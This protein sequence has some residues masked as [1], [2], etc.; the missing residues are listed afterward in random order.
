MP[1]RWSWIAL[2]AGAYLAFL[3]ATFPASAAYR[4]FAPPELRMSGVAGTVWSGSASLA[5]MNG[6]PLRDL[7]WNLS[8][9][10]LLLGRAHAVFETRL[11][12]GFVRGESVATVSYIALRN[13]QVSTRLQ[14]LA[15]LLPV[16]DTRGAVSLDVTSLVIEDGWPVELVGLARAAQIEVAPLFPTQNGGLI[17]LG[18]YEVEFAPTDSGR[19]SGRVRDSG[20]PLEVSGTVMVDADRSYVL[21]GV[22]RPRSEASPDIVRG[23]EF[24]TG[25]PDESGW[26]SFS[27]TGSL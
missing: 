27:L 14:T 6:L 7:R 12:D 5:S 16:Q 18:S 26:R 9:W 11:E 22:V 21:E 8:A 4:W 10:P 2:G 3:L 13:L 20:G 15:A 24:M 1:T 19:I 17:L 25:E 23:L